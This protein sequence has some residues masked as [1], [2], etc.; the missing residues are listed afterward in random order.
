MKKIK[1]LALITFAG[2]ALF[3]LFLNSTTPPECTPLNNISNLV[4][5]NTCGTLTYS[6]FLN[7]G[8]TDTSKKNKIPDFS[9]AGYRQGGV[10]IP[11]LAERVRVPVMPGDS[12]ARI[13][14]AIDQ[15]SALQPNKHGHRG[16]V[17]LD[18]GFYRVDGTIYIRAS[19]VVLR[20]QGQHPDG[21][22]IVSGMKIKGTV[23]QLESKNKVI[24]FPETVTPIR[25][26]Y[27]GT[28]SRAFFV[29]NGSHFK[30]GDTILIYRTPNDE[31]IQDL[32]MNNIS[33]YPNARADVQDWK[34]SDY[35]ISHE[36][37]ITY[38]NGGHINIDIPLVD[39]IDSK[40]GGGFI[41]KIDK[42]AAYVEEVGVEDLRIISGY[43]N[44]RDEDHAWN[45]IRLQSVQNGW[46]RR[47]TAQNFAY[48]TVYVSKSNF[49]TVEDSASLNPVSVIDGGKRYSFNISD[50][51]LGVLFQRVYSDSGRHS[52]VTGA[53]VRGPHAWVDSMVV[54]AK[55]DDGP[56]HRWATGLLF[57][58]T[59]SNEVAVQNRGPSGTGHGWSGAQVMFWRNTVNTF[60]LQA[61]PG[62]MSWAV[63]VEGKSVAGLD[64]PVKAYGIVKGTTDAQPRSLYF[65]QL[66]DRN[67]KQRSP[68]AVATAPQLAGRAHTILDLLT[69]APASGADPTCANGTRSADGETCCAASCGSCGGKS[70]SQNNGGAKNCCAGIIKTSGKSCLEGG[71][72]CNISRVP[73]NGFETV[74]ADPMCSR[75]IKSGGTC[76]APGCGKCG[77]TECSARPG[78]KNACCTG[79]IEQTQR[80][81]ANTEAPCMIPFGASN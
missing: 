37:K 57:D 71:A 3:F 12:T 30:V 44:T 76:C 58:N 63:G 16:A 24:T 40:Y 43:L 21:T 20:G 65:Q 73:A 69:R 14:A 15:V 28:G 9:Y 70:C 47:V 64:S 18:R 41:A 34:A 8:E 42:S 32:D 80:S 5:L 23:I 53:K 66:K 36:R 29:N 22:N 78:G 45:A 52:F 77:G 79:A 35:Q 81:C 67:D 38:R 68:E 51:G 27:A 39:P 74:M 49:V 10:A 1:L 26:I 46:V 19:G 13:Q 2:C 56:H 72:P 33:R 4:R 6:S 48:A 7:I 17:V 62:S 60:I 50:S 31:W 75:G 59:K 61:A 54:N 11:D 55:A 25:D